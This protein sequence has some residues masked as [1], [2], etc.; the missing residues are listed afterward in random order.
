MK[1][2]APIGSNRLGGWSRA[3]RPIGD[4]IA[5]YN[6]DGSIRSVGHDI[7]DLLTGFVREISAVK[8]EASR[9]DDQVGVLQS[10]AEQFAG[11]VG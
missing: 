1:R 9:I 10:A 4:R 3:A 5:D 8:E 7:A 6:W 11:S 2:E